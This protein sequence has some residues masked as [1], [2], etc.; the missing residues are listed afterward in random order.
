MYGY[1]VINMEISQAWKDHL[2]TIGKLGGKAKSVQKTI[3]ARQNA[4]L[5]GW[6]KGRKRKTPMASVENKPLTSEA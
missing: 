2:S 4:K 6:P 3:A 5:G 1:D